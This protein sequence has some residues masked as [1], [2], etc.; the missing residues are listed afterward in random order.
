MIHEYYKRV[1]TGIRKWNL[2]I[3][4]IES[5]GRELFEQELFKHRNL[6]MRMG[7]RPHTIG[8][9]GSPHDKGGNGNVNY[10]LNKT[11][12]FVVV[13]LNPLVPDESDALFIL[14]TDGFSLGMFKYHLT[15][16]YM[17]YVY[18]AF[19]LWQTRLDVFIHQLTGGIKRGF[20]FLKLI[21]ER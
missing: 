10:A 16:P 15:D 20:K 3:R 18:K 1:S 4:E 14:A 7:I 17:I 12:K 9:V 19:A 8:N 5:S 21:L 11:G 2:K 6:V 13:R